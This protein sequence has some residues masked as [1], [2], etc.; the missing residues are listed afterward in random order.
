MIGRYSKLIWLSVILLALIAVITVVMTMDI[1][2]VLFKNLSIAGIQEKQLVIE[3]LM[4][5]EHGE[6]GKNAAQKEQLQM[7]KNKFD[8][9]KSEYESIDESTITIVQDATKEVKYFIE[10]LWIVLG[11]YATANKVEIDIQTPGSTISK[12]VEETEGTTESN[13]YTSDVASTAISSGVTTSSNTGIKISVKGRYANI[14]DFVFDVENDK[15]LKFKLDN[16]KMD[17][18]KDN[19]VLATFD[20]LSL[21][22]L[23]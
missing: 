11:N 10:Y 7:S 16:I 4:A 19:K 8:I 3:N 17:Y 20:V 21:A 22:V 2:L 15:S 13:A 5:K 12:P 18:A 23:K 6:V 14:A 1:D 9:A